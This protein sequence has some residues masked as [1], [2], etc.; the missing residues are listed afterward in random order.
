MSDTG[1][2][3]PVQKISPPS[4]DRRSRDEIIANLYAH[5]PGFLPGWQPLPGEPG[6]ALLAVFSR[7]LE[8]LAQGANQ[9]A[10]R[11]FLAFLSLMGVELLPATSARA[12]L[13]FSLMPTSPVDIPLP[14]NS[15]VAAPAQPK[16]PSPLLGETSTET[17]EP[18]IFATTQAITLTRARLAALYSLLPDSDEY[19]DHTAS[20][21]TGFTLFADPK[22]VEHAIYLGHD[23]LFALA[24]E[25]DVRLALIPG[26]LPRDVTTQ[27]P[28]MEWEYLSKDGWLPLDIEDDRTQNLTQGG[29]IL[30]RKSCGPD[31]KE[32]TIDGHKSYWLRGR[33]ATP[34]LQQGHEGLAS[35]PQIDTLKARVGFTKK[36]LQPEGAFIDQTKLNTANAFNP[37][38]LQPER[39]ATFYLASKEAFQRRSAR[40]AVQFTM[41]QAGT[42]STSPVLAQDWEY[43]NGTDWLPLSSGFDFSD[44]TDRF[45][46]SGSI[47][48]AC[49][50]DWGETEVNGE[51]NFWLRARIS[52]GDYGHP[53]RLKVT[54][55]GSTYTIEVEDATLAPP[56]VKR[57]DIQ[58][59]YQTDL[60]P[61][62]H[63]LT[64]NNFVYEDRT[65]ACFWPR[66]TFTPF[67]PLPERRPAV[68]FGFDQPLP[69]GLVSLYLQAPSLP[70]ESATPQASPF[71][72]EYRSPR[73]WSELGVLDET[74]GFST[75]GLLQFVGPRDAVAEP[76]VGGN[77]Y[78]I[79]A[80]LKTGE[81]LRTFA[82]Q[83]A[84]LNAVWGTQRQVFDRETLGISDGSANQSFPF[85]RRQ[86]PV[87]EG[88]MIEVREW[89]GRGSDWETA[90]LGV[91]EAD[92]RL[93]TD[94]VT[95][96]AIAAWVTWHS[97]P[98]LFA[99]QPG[100]RHYVIERSA[101]LLRFGDGEC[102]LVP[103]AGARISATYNS[104]GG[105]A[106]N[107]AV[108]AINELRTGAPYLMG[109]SNPVA[110]EGGAESEA[111][112]AVRPRGAQVLRHRDQAISAEDIQWLAVQ[113][114]PGVARTRCLPITGPDGRAQRGW[115]TVI[116]LPHSREAQPQPTSGLLHQ[117]RNYLVERLPATAARHLRLSG[118][119]Y[120]AVSVAAEVVPVLPTEAARVEARLRERLNNF[121][122]PLYGGNESKG[123]AF[124]Q[125]L[126]LSDIA[127]V[128]ETTPGVDYARQVELRVGDQK[129]AAEV[130]VP[131]DAL[132]AAGD[133]ELKLMIGTD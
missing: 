77:H 16:P 28:V 30:L 98:H 59:T 7:Y 47:S 69:S 33:L 22:P 95:G 53:L 51:K 116:I 37:F 101:G 108:G 94:P 40:V 125:A 36:G 114:S 74:G 67:Y 9:T 49:P 3:L 44:G 124:G 10:D 87:L 78:R 88:E 96:E 27:H 6:A 106:G 14:A 43:F 62:D 4:L 42:A 11:S 120:I 91:E 127:R 100:D 80:R 25:A 34:L 13:V 35:L 26:P 103:P 107:V 65:Q 23:S 126:Y 12:P 19:S 1:L 17:P 85:L 112:A 64:F 48:F 2:H 38:G 118:P 76:G 111:L 105:L 115:V 15:Q 92:R 86:G 58:Y 32:D 24:G 72:W 60:A 84:W 5:L 90:L 29:Q 8:V 133:H 79:R 129:F 41:A 55:S 71:V 45:T 82:L 56:V 99:S 21:T 130:P 52:D 110:A 68:Y 54:P 75:S 104:G 128:I 46:K 102:G 20:L 81:S 31:A 50:L 123:W 66:Q 39:F 97:R 131:R 57:V 83:G 121:L 122:H 63:C 61:L 132:L 93:E 117:V 18:A 119:A 73:G 70:A 109:V 113:A 89:T